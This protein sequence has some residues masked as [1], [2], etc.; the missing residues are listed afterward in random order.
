ME[1]QMFGDDS[2]LCHILFTATWMTADE[3]RYNLFTQIL[4][5]VNA[6][7]LALELVELLERGLAH[8]I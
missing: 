4:F 8:Q 6:V 7:K 5:A 1:I 3:I 2:Q